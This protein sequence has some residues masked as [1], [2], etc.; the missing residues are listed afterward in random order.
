MNISCY[1]SDPPKGFEMYKSMIVGLNTCRLA[2]SLRENPVIH[3][4]WIK[5]LW[6]NSTAKKGDTVIKSRVQ[7]KEVSIS[8]QDIRDVLLFGDAA[9]DPIEYSKEKVIEVLVKMSY[10]GADPPPTIKKLLHP[11][12]RFL[13]HIY[14][15][16][17]SG[18]KS[19][20]DK[21]TL[22]QTSAVVSVVE[23]WNY[24]YSKSVFNDMFVN[25]KM[26]NEKYWYK[27]PRF[28]QMILEKKYP[29]L[30]VIVKTYDVK[31]MNHLVFTWINQKS[32]ENV[33]IKYQ[34]KRN[35]EKFG[36]FSEFQEEAPAQINAIVAEEHDVEII[37]APVGVQEPIKNVDLTSIESEEDVADDRMI[38]DEEVDESGELVMRVKQR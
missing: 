34:N 21:L 15:V 36:A 8:E 24:N 9:D 20:L 16:C 32:R 12:W 28:I 11:Y 1:L 17:I 5:D 35:L 22:K 38:D 7:G 31:M 6:D 10:E 3:E 25:V 37:E 2:H 30:P 4:D 29:K 18:N 14:L 19:G 27:F 33:G 13:A 23:G 26:L